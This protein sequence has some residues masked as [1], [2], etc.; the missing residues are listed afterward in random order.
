MT[1]FSF[2]WWNCAFCEFKNS[3]RPLADVLQR[4]VVL[5]SHSAF[6]AT[7]VRPFFQFFRICLPSLPGTEKVIP[8]KAAGSSKS[9]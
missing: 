3:T 2:F 8:E 7:L 6:S 5:L 4:H 1:V 9:Q